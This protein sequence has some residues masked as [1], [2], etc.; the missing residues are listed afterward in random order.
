[1]MKGSE[2]ALGLSVRGYMGGIWAVFVPSVAQRHCLM[3]FSG[4]HVP[5]WRVSRGDRAWEMRR[6]KGLKEKPTFSSFRCLQCVL[7][8]SQGNGGRCYCFSCFSSDFCL[9]KSLLQ[10]LDLRY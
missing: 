7:G 1:M 3:A 8:K 2:L 6:V 9:L 5:I 10:R 4:W